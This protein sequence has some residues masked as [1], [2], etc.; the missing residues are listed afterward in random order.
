MSLSVQ[1][2]VTRGNFQ[3]KLDH[4]FNSAGITAVNGPS[5]CGK[6]TLL[7][8]IAGLDKHADAELSHGQQPWQSSSVFF[9][10]EKRRIGYVSQCPSLFPHLSV[11][12]NISYGINDDA[13]RFSSDSL[14]LIIDSLGLNQLL[15]KQP[16]ALSG[17]QQQRVSLARA[18]VS[19]PQ[20]LLLDEPLTG[21]DSR[22]KAAVLAQLR[23]IT[24]EMGIPVIYVTHSLDEIA[25]AAD[26]LILMD[27]GQIIADGPVNSI[28]TS[29]NL[30]LAFQD[31]AESVLVATA[32]ERQPTQG[33]SELSL[34]GSPVFVS[35]LALASDQAVRLR[36]AARDVSLTLD[37][38]RNTSILNVIPATIADIKPHANS[39][40]TVALDISG[41]TLLAKI[42]QRS[43]TLLSL[44][45]GQAVYAQV[46]GIAVH[47]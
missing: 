15:D 21:L 25:Q 30:P 26:Q 33:L 16:N 32:S 6:S 27:A 10:P 18:L 14:S 35:Q 23:Q 12:S 5:G 22:S 8:A 44:A 41:Q 3:L 2:S 34:A 1:L 17:G 31:D 19:A 7:R 43:A 37:K 36:I 9:P 20:L 4:C 42:T 38:P 39:Q 28:C 47:A 13:R 45:A 40:V 24:S 11:A 29:M 46:K